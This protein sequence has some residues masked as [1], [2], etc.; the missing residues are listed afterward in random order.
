MISGF[1]DHT[2]GSVAVAVSFGA[3]VM[4]TS[5]LDKSIGGVDAKFSM[6][7][8]NLKRWWE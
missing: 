7:K 8:M 2:L 6:D 5:I 1:S 4:K 3:K